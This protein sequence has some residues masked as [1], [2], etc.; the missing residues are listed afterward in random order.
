M[1]R[2]IATGWLL[3]QCSD[4]VAVDLRQIIRFPDEYIQ[5]RQGEL[6]NF[7]GKAQADMVLVKS[8]Y[9]GDKLLFGT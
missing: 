6:V 2:L 7:I 1:P 3:R 9:Q 4:L 5:E 8:L